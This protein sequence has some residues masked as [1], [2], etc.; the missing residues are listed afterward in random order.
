VG[1]GNANQTTGHEGGSTWLPAEVDVS[2]RPGWFYH[3]GEDDQVKGLDHLVDIYY[4]SVGLNGLL[5]LNVPPDRRGLIHERDVARLRGLREVID[6]T[7][8]TDLAAGRPAAA[9]QVRGGSAEYAAARAV[10]GDPDTY[11]ATDDDVRQATLTVDLGEPTAFDRVMLQEAI[12]LGQRVKGF[13]VEALVAEAG[14]ERWIELGR[15]LTIGHKRLL[16]FPAVTAR[17]VRLRIE[18]ARACPVISRFGVFLAPPAVTITPD[19]LGYMAGERFEVT[20]ACEVPTAAIHYTLDGTAPTEAS[21]RYTAPLLLDRTT[22]VTAVAYAGQQASLRP[23]MATFRRLTVDDLLPAVGEGPGPAGVSYTYYEGGWQSL[24]DLPHATPVASGAADGFD[25][26]VRRRDE[27]FALSFET[28]I[29]A[30]VDGIYRFATR[31]SDGSMLWVDGR[32]VVDNDGLHPVVEQHGEAP[33]R[34]GRHHVM[35]ACF[36]TRGP[37]SLEV[38]WQPPHGDLQPLPTP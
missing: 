37:A 30:P 7:F 15:G 20:L 2:I 16:R 29:A 14:A 31:S 32:L 27:H 1:G 12:A 36:K 8:R 26:G 5:L 11:W 9:D 24:R 22:T 4:H 21:M 28:H 33:L 23:A 19:T 34:A 38:L 25:L 10:D 17:A 18:D 6:A 35:V 3:S 13:A